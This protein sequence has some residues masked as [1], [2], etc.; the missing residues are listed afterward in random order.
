VD[1][2]LP[3]MTPPIHWIRDDK[4]LLERVESIRGGSLAVDTESDSLHHY[5]ERV[6]LVQLTHLGR[7]EL[8]DP[9]AGVDLSILAPLLSDASLPKL[10][11]GADYDLRLLHR[12]F[13]L[14][15]SGLFDTMVASRLTGERS[16]GLAALLSKH[17]DVELDK[18]YQRADWSRR[19]LTPEMEQYAA[20]DTRFLEDL[21]D[22]LATE[23]KRLGRM[24]WAT[25]E[26]R[27]LEGVRFRERNDEEPF[28][29]VKGHGKLSAQTQ[30]VLN[31]LCQFREQVA[32][33]KARPPFRI[34][35]DAVLLTLAARGPDDL[36]NFTTVQ[37]LPRSYRSGAGAERLLRVL[38]EAW[39]LPETD[40]PSR[41]GE[42]RK[43]RRSASF[44]ARIKDWK[45]RRDV[46]A[47]EL[48]L[49]SSIVASRGILEGLLERVEAGE[50][51]SAH[52]D[53]RRWQWNL[54]SGFPGLSA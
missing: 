37:G 48:H 24:E 1:A 12:E 6:C 54:L 41:V 42:G 19:P 29:R 38:E 28:R 45:T 11:H 16:F 3:A 2:S 9:L 43:P 44:E 22:L 7:D 14:E 17:F 50:D 51:P 39:S 4:R 32:R 33:H 26:F 25:E 13:G 46:I 35:S 20:M 52:P 21:V 47:D 8:I 34:V 18:R 53:L 49:E 36:R 23:L 10:F 5:P 31:R 40:W 27:R 15:V 30:A